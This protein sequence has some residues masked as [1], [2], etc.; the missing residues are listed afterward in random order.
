[1]KW[2]SRR[3]KRKETRSLQAGE[4]DTEASKGGRNER[5]NNKQARRVN[6]KSGTTSQPTDVRPK[7]IDIKERVKKITFQQ[8]S[9]KRKA[10]PTPTRPHKYPRKN[11]GHDKVLFSQQNRNRSHRTHSRSDVEEREFTNMV[12]KYHRRLGKH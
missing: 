8:E 9:R 11:G 2:Q 12:T 6:R 4:Q 1:M 5:V 7:K 3:Q 10:E